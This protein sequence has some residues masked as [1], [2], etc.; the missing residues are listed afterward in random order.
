MPTL[1]FITRQSVKKLFLVLVFLLAAFA[2]QSQT[3]IGTMSLGGFVQKNVVAELTI[4]GK[5]AVL[6]MRQVRFSRFMPVKID[7]T[8]DDIKVV[9]EATADNN[10][11]TLTAEGTL[12]LSGGK[13]YEKYV[14]TKG[15]GTAGRD[16]DFSCMMGEKRVTYKGSLKKK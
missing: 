3:Y 4:S 8:I 1:F 15:H 10:V 13:R 14:I 16:V 6:I 2:A 7:V 12:P 11:T 5:T 9:S